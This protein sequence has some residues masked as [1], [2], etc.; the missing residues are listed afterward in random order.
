MFSLTHYETPCPEP[1]NAQILQMVVDYLTDIS[2]VAIPPSNLLYN[3]YQ[4]AIGYEVHLYLEALGGSKGIAVEL[5]VALDAQ[6]QVIGFLLYLPVKDDPE[7]C[8]VA[9]MAVHASHRR[10]GVARAMMQDILARYPHAELTCAVEKVPA[11][12]S[13]GFQLRGVRGTQVL[14]NTRDYSTDGLMGLLDVASIYS[15]LEV[16]QIHTYLLQKHGKRA[17]VDAEKQR[18]R[19]FDQMTHKAR[20]FVHARLG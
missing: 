20:M 16:R 10:K 14:M 2:M 17:M 6:E 11:F 7:A 4:Y 5:I 8:G 13:M 18:D 1:I 12:E 19:H 15:S 3:V 9:Y